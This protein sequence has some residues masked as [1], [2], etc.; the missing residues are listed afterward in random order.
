[1]RSCNRSSTGRDG[2]MTVWR[3]SCER[4]CSISPSKHVS[5][6]NQITDDDRS[7]CRGGPVFGRLDVEPQIAAFGTLSS[8]EDRMMWRRSLCRAKLLDL[9]PNIPGKKGGGAVPARSWLCLTREPRPPYPGSGRPDRSCTAVADHHIDDPRPR[10]V[11]SLSDRRQHA[12][13]QPSL[14][15]GSG[16]SDLEDG[17][18]ALPLRTTPAIVTSFGM[19]LS[20]K[21]VS[22]M[23]CCCATTESSRLLTP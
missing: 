10:A 22:A 19:S 9:Q 23:L 2:R 16:C 20:L 5:I 3:K 4:R 6:R 14:L 17:H 1:M 15:A 18:H 11:R 8:D 7:L 13:R 12:R 21:K